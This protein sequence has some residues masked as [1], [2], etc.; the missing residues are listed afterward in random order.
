[1]TVSDFAVVMYGAGVVKDHAIIVRDEETL[2]DDRMEFLR[3][4]DEYSPEKMWFAGAEIQSVHMFSDKNV[5]EI[6]YNPD[7]ITV[8]TI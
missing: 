2:Y 5:R 7:Y 8:I 6:D 4:A 3:Y 1:M